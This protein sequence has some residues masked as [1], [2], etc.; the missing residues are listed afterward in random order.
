M[1]Y[2]K[3]APVDINEGNQRTPS[4]MGG[5]FN[6]VVQTESRSMNEIH[7][8]LGQILDELK[9]QRRDR[10]MAEFQSLARDYD[11]RFNGLN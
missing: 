8:V 9:S 1:P 4:A 11:E 10:T 2:D 7:D 5:T 6:P 3:T